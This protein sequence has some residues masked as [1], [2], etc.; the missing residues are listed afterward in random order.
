MSIATDIIAEL[1]R[2]DAGLLD[3]HEELSRRAVDVADVAIR[4]G[5]H[6]RVYT[7]ADGSRVALDLLRGWYW[8]IRL[9]SR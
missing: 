4:A 6:D 3:A 9:S 7:F 5:G 2:A 8:A 1:D